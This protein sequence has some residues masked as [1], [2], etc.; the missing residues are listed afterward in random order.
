[1]SVVKPKQWQKPRKATLRNFLF[2]GLVGFVGSLAVIS[3]FL[4]VI[5]SLIFVRIDLP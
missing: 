2:A 3:L 5:V 1:M 4:L